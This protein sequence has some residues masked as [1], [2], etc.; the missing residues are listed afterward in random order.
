M[1][2]FFLFLAFLSL[3]RTPFFF[4]FFLIFRDGIPQLVLRCTY[5]FVPG[6]CFIPS[7]R[8]LALFV[9]KDWLSR[10]EL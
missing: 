9:M 3:F 8:V 5:Y 10:N 1:L 7:R 6:T 4:S 2:V